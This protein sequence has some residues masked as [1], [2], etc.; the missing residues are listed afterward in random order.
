[1]VA[2]YEDTD[3]DVTAEQ[4]PRMHLRRVMPVWIVDGQSEIGFVP[5]L[6]GAFK[7]YGAGV[8]F[9]DTGTLSH[10]TNQ[11]TGAAGAITTALGGTGGAVVESLEQAGK[12]TAALTPPDPALKALQ[13]QVARKELE[14]KLA[15]AM[16][17]IASSGNGV[18][19]ATT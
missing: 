16:K 10:L 8:E 18:P 3:D 13:D 19:A 14:A 17:T 1:Q 5:F 15:T 12:I 2:V 11:H 7:E 6:S 4:S 9:G